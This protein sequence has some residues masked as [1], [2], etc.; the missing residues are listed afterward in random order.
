MN[1]NE[2]K[3]TI[4]ENLILYVTQ[5]DK[6]FFNYLIDKYIKNLIDSFESYYSSAQNSENFSYT[7]WQK[8]ETDKINN[9]YLTQEENDINKFKLCFV[10]LMMYDKNYKGSS[11]EYE[12]VNGDS[13]NFIIV[14]GPKK[15]KENKITFGS[16]PF[17]NI[18]I[19]SLNRDDYWAT[20]NAYEFLHNETLFN[21]KELKATCVHF[22]KD[23]DLSMEATQELNFKN[24]G[25]KV[26]PKQTIT[27][28]RID[29]IME[30][31][32]G[33]SILIFPE[34][35][36]DSESTKL[37][38][39][40]TQRFKLIIS[41]S[42]YVAK[43]GHYTNTAYCSVKSGSAWYKELFSYNKRI[44]FS[45]GYTPEVAEAYHISTYVYPLNKSDL[46]VEDIVVDDRITILP[47]K[48]CIVGI[49]ICRDVLDLLDK[50]NPLHKYCDFVDLMLVISENNG[51]TNMFVGIA[52]C[53][54]RW[55]NCATLYTNALHEAGSTPDPFLE[56]S[57]A[58]YPYKKTD[59]SANDYTRSSTSVSGE[60]T[61]AAKLNEKNYD[62][63]HPVVTILNSKGIKYHQL[64]DEEKTSGCK[65]YTFKTE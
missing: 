5:K 7:E 26:T 46:L 38:D 2:D 33:S 61:Y 53:L 17:Q 15:W 9:A 24:L 52:E 56:M 54:A 27:K 6:Y 13:L 11:L 4:K 31:A 21:G 8:I 35:Q 14:F 28:D 64:T 49:A 50:N 23:A 47:Y 19:I 65:E 60:I 62:K 1:A 18:R 34:L 63:K 43:D 36:V 45:M 55:H 40:Y 42:R 41:G 48:D 12:F 30:K 20:N 58:L 3:S 10:T 29:K 32:R 22:T 44:P 51:D 57:F 25:I 16:C 39:A 37:I 59:P